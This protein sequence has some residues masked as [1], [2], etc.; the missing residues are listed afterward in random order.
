MFGDPVTNPKGWKVTI[1]GLHADILSGFPFESS[2]YTASGIRICGG[3]II[4]QDSIL[5][6][7]CKYWTSLDGYEEYQLEA[8]DIVMAMDRPWIS[9]GFKIAKIKGNV[10]PALLIQRTAR[11]RS[12]DINQEY[13]YNIFRHGGFDKHCNVTGS[14]VPHISIN[15]IRSFRIMLPPFSL[16][17]QFADFA[18]AVEFQKSLLQQSLVKMELNYKSLM[19]KCFT[20]EV[21]K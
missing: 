12:S 10:L 16:Q 2:Q 3:L 13:L 7:E 9:Q 17:N 8:N 21:F 14:L 5:W 4:M 15:D 20:M 1:V 6:E 18:Q 11:I 19:K